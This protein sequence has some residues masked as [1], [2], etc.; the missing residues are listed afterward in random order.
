MEKYDV[1]KQEKRTL[2]NSLTELCHRLKTI[3]QQNLATNVTATTATVSQPVSDTVS[4]TT[5]INTLTC[6]NILWIEFLVFVLQNFSKYFFH[7]H[8]PIFVRQFY[9]AIFALYHSWLAYPSFMRQNWD[10]ESKSFHTFACSIFLCPHQIW[11]IDLSVQT[12]IIYVW[13]GFTRS[14]GIPRSA[15]RI[16]WKM[17]L[18]ITTC[19]FVATKLCEKFS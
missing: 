7:I 8:N 19:K 16:S 13:W 17:K 3:S 11:K 4:N 10:L 6:M 2:E 18:G 14:I 5:G 12:S 15:I 9:V 1:T